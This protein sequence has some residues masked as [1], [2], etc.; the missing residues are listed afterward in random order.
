M[1]PQPAGERSDE[2]NSMNR[3]PAWRWSYN[4]RADFDGKASDVLYP[5]PILQGHF[6]ISIAIS[7]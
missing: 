3:S 7:A 6:D 5:S 2:G 1:I 4:L